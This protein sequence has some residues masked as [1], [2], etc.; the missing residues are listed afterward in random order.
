MQ[1]NSIDANELKKIK[2]KNIEEQK[3]NSV[4]RIFDGILDK[5]EVVKKIF[6]PS[7]KMVYLVS[8]I[9]PTMFFLGLILISLIL[10]LH[11]Q[12]ILN[13]SDFLI[14]AIGISVI[15]IIAV[16]IIYLITKKSLQSTYYVI[17][18]KRVII[19]FGLLRNDFKWIKLKDIKDVKL[20]WG[21]IGKI[22]RKNFG[23]ICFSSTQKE[24]VN[25]VFDML[26]KPLETYIEIEN[27]L[28]EKHG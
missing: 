5:D 21:F 1:N 3:E 6:S 9:K 4:A 2:I 20:N 8:L 25:I 13:L 16:L 11:P 27:F 23:Q 12:K 14:S 28:G 15:T 18:N 19:S 26:N 24:E 17:T 10:Y 7:R 22:T